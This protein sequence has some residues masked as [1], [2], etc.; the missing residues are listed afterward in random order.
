MQEQPAKGILTAILFV[1]VSLSIAVPAQAKIHFKGSV[2]RNLCLDSF[3]IGE[4]I[5][6]PHFDDVKWII[7]TKGLINSTCDGIGCQP[8]NEFRGYPTAEQKELSKALSVEYGLNAY[9]LIT[10]NDLAVLRQYHYDCN[11]SAHG[12]WSQRRFVGFY[13]SAPSRYLTLV[14]LRLING[15]LTIYRIAR[16]FPFHTPEEL[17]S[18]AKEVRKQYGR[19]ILIYD[20][21]S[22]NAY[23]EVISLQKD[24]WFGRST[25][26]NPSD[27][28]DND[29]E[30]VLIDPRT[31]RLLQPTSMPDSGDISPLPARL[32]SECNRS[33]PLQ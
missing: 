7:P 21:I 31:R 30:L 4:T 27:L 26:F 8:Q 3:C 20:G 10:N 17:L 22:S 29:A 28:A 33:V 18:L 2:D 24:G 14:G 9:N 32:P 19:R 6:S 5:A 23:S 1:F 13:F 15:Q 16:Q 11:P 12:M 25:L